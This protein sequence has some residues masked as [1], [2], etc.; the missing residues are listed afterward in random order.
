VIAATTVIGAGER[1]DAATS[2]RQKA[3]RAALRF[4]LARASITDLIR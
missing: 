3:R 1:I 2:A 4:G